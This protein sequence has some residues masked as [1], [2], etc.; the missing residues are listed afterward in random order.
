MSL[1]C[2]VSIVSLLLAPLLLELE[3]ARGLLLLLVYLQ[4]ARGVDVDGPDTSIVVSATGG[5]MADVGGEEDTRYVG[6]VSLEGS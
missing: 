5:E 6:G 1:D 2:R 3:V 4:F